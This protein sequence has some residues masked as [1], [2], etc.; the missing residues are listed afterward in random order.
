MSIGAVASASA[1]VYQAPAYAPMTAA[2]AAPTNAAHGTDNDRDDAPRA[3]QN[4]LVS[5]M[6]AALQALGV[7]QG[8]VNAPTATATAP[9]APPAVA[10]VTAPATGAA[11]AVT[12]PATP[13][14]TAS[15]DAIKQ[16]VQDFAHA[17]FDALHHAG[18]GDHA[19][20]L[21]ENSHGGERQNSRVHGYD[22]FSQRLQKLALSLGAAA[23]VPADASAGASGPAPAAP[24]RAATRL[25]DA[26]TK[27]MGLLQPPTSVAPLVAPAT[28]ATTATPA[29]PAAPVDAVV[30]APAAS[31]GATSVADK[32]KQF[33]LAM[34]Q[35]LRPSSSHPPPNAVGS[36][37]NATA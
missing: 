24:G 23:A 6:M 29:A 35:A 15:A 17:L 22:G 30:V 7:G 28:T 33:L 9:A 10:P 32:L 27:L 25:L 37:V 31:S 20:H 2:A 13:D 26:F 19:H 1:G 8:A 34:A 14:V 16:A 18:R 36:L 12:P 3:G 5:A 4:S 21:D 11:N